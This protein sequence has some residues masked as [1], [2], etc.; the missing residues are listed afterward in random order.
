MTRSVVYATA[1]SCWASYLINGDASG[2][3]VDEIA[4]C[5]AW[6]KR[7][8]CGLPVDCED[9]GFHWHHDASKEM[10]LGADCQRYAFLV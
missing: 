6:I 4:A 9:D 10:P 1:P 7:E 3:S 8:D 2:L 5:D